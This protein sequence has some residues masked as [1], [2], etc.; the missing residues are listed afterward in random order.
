MQTPFSTSVRAWILRPMMAA[1]LTLMVAG[2]TLAQDL[3]A[4]DS[5]ARSFKTEQKPPGLVIGI[6]D[7]SEKHVLRYGVASVEDSVRLSANTPFEIGSV[8]K[9]FTALLLAEMAQRGAVDPSDPIGRYLPDSVQAPAFDGQSI[10]LQH[11]ATHTSGLPRL[12]D[13]L[14][15]PSMT[16][17]YADYTAAKLYTFLDGFKLSHP[18]GAQYAYSN[19]GGG[20]LGH[21]LARRADTSFAAL[22]R[23]RVLQPL[24][25]D[26]TRF[27]AAPGSADAALAQ[28]YASTGP[29]AYW[30]WDVLAGAGALRSTPADL[31]RFLQ[32]QLDAEGIPLASAIRETHRIRHRASKQLALT[33][34]WHVST[35][36]DGTRLYWHN[37]GTGGFRSFVGFIPGND[38]ALVVLTNR[39]LPLQAFNRFAFQLVRAS[40]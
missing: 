26:D 28:G 15:P 7:S 34:G 39:A 22:L 12:P 4:V 13:N 11:L 37:G 14:S 10:Q 9:T 20:L 32:M 31:L 35:A 17:P 2:P 23:S 5:L 38:T 24:G 6:V 8:T 33:L 40:L 18:P 30:H 29:A 19:L 21:L 3:A 27:P 36:P 16:D 1:L 25:L